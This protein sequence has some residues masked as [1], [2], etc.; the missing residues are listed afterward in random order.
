MWKNKFPEPGVECV[1]VTKPQARVTHISP[2]LHAIAFKETSRV[3][4]DLREE[5]TKN[6][7]T[8]VWY[9]LVQHLTSIGLLLHFARERPESRVVWSTPRL[10]EVGVEA[11]SHGLRARNCA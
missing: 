2:G 9:C 4:E 5:K 7:V 11:G 10:T 6:S 3:D 1:C 8:I